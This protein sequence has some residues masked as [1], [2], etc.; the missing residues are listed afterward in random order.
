[1]SHTVRSVRS[2][3]DMAVFSSHSPRVSVATGS[4][5]SAVSGPGSR[6]TDRAAA[7]VLVPCGRPPGMLAR[8]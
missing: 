1:M 4:W 5:H 6:C 2:C 3:M 8:R 7:P